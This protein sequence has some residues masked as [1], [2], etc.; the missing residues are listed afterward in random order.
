MADVMHRILHG[1]G[2]I[3]DIDLLNSI[4]TNIIGNT[5]CALGDAAAMPVQGFIKYYRND[6]E[7]YINSKKLNK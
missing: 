1:H 5:I 4:A 7:L 3:S 6:L 2:E